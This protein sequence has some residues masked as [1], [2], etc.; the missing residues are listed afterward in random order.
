M[1]EWH[2]L[3]DPDTLGYLAVLLLW[4]FYQRLKNLQIEIR[5]GHCCLDHERSSLSLSAWQL[6]HFL[7]QDAQNDGRLP[8]NSHALLPVHEDYWLRG[9]IPYP[10]YA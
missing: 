9:D 3:S 10:Q 1:I 4:L 5:I 7:S 2:H 6:Q 8:P